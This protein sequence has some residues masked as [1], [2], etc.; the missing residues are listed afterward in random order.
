MEQELLKLLS[1]AGA[2]G[3]LVFFAVK[4]GIKAIEKLYLDMREQHKEQLQESIKRE[5]KLMDWLDKKNESDV[6]IANTLQNIS[7]EMQ[8]INNRI[9]T[10]EKKLPPGI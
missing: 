9:D 3:A 2:L 5:D 7:E 8:C 1:G 6:K 4:Y 10:I